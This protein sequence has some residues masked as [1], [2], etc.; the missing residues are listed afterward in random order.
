MWKIFS[1][2]N[3][4]VLVS[5]LKLENSVW[6]IYPSIPQNSLQ[7]DLVSQQHEHTWSIST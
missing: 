2:K 5:K 6:I 4:G 3:Q 7:N 1:K